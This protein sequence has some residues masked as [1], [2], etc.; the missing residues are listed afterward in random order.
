MFINIPILDY[1]RFSANMIIFKLFL[2]LSARVVLGHFYLPFLLFQISQAKNKENIL[3]GSRIFD[4]STYYKWYCTN[5]LFLNDCCNTNWYA[6]PV[7]LENK[8]YELSF[9]SEANT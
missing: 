9:C 7:I 1:L 8:N 2:N 3:T 5:V 4:Y 6:T